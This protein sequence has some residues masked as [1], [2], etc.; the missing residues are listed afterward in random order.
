MMTFQE[1]LSL[2]KNGD[3]QAEETI[4]LRYQPLLLKM[5]LVDGVFDED[6]YQE[7]SIVLIHCIRTFRN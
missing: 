5:A 6:L 2:A 4:Y 1:L 7:L 3:Q